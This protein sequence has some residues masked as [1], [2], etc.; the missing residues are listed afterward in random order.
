MSSLDRIGPQAGN[1]DSELGSAHRRLEGNFHHCIHETREES[2]HRRL[3]GHRMRLGLCIF[4]HHIHVK[5]EESAMAGKLDSLQ[6]EIGVQ[7]R[8]GHEI[9]DHNGSEIGNSLQQDRKTG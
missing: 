6:V 7:L 3:E 8:V 5:R 4:D 9:Q 1:W 2:A